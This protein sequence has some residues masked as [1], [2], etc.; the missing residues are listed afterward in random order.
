MV[1]PLSYSS[2]HFCGAGCRSAS[3]NRS[4]LLGVPGTGF[5]RQR[6]RSNQFHTPDNTTSPAAIAAVCHAMRM[7]SVQ[8]MFCKPTGPI[9]I[10]HNPLPAFYPSSLTIRAR[11]DRKHPIREIWRRC[12]SAFA[13]NTTSATNRTLI[14]LFLRPAL[15]TND[16][17][18]FNSTQ[19]PKPTSHRAMQDAVADHPFSLSEVKRRITTLSC[20]NTVW[21]GRHCTNPRSCPYTTAHVPSRRS[22]TG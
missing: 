19:S 10:Q 7:W 20:T 17:F 15:L 16:D 13:F 12:G 1:S 5:L 22:C 9:L 6:R 3:F 8:F 4:A 14:N 2:Y 21:K 18:H 11:P